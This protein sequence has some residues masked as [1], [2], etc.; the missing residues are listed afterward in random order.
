[1]RLELTGRSLC[2]GSLLLALASGS[3]LAQSASAP[4]V[5]RLLAGVWRAVPGGLYAEDDGG[6]RVYP[7]GEAAT[8][9]FVMT[10]DGFGA[11]T[12]QAAGRASC[13]TGPGPR[14]CSAAE[15]EAAFQTASSYQ[16]RYRLEPD[17]DNPYRGKIIWDVD[18]SVYPNWVGQTL[19]RRYDLQPDGSGWTLLSPLPANPKLAFQAHLVRDR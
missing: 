13:A 9:R 18:L 1:M 3:C 19:V 16:Y 14:Q 15:A 6:K 2:L 12:L 10:S 17:A 4:D 11:N 5:A 7:F 8:A